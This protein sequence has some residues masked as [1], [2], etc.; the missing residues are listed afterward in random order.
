MDYNTFDKFMG[1]K[2]TVKYVIAINGL[3]NEKYIL[4]IF[5]SSHDN[6]IDMTYIA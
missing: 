1:D 4:Y 3:L 5:L 2:L 6:P